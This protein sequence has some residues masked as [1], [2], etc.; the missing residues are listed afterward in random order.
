M[1]PTQGLIERAARALAASILPG[2]WLTQGEAARKWYRAM[3]EP[4][5]MAYGTDLEDRALREPHARDC[6]QDPCTCWK[7]RILSAIRG[8]PC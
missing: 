1:N 5:L 2:A 7:G 3:A 4:V 8:V 6:L